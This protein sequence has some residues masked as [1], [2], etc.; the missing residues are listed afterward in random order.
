MTSAPRTPQHAWYADGEAEATTRDRLVRLAGPVA[1]DAGA[2]G[3]ETTGTRSAGGR[4]PAAP[5]DEVPRT[6]PGLRERALAAAVTGYTA[7]HGHPLDHRWADGGEHRAAP[8]RWGVRPAA[9]AVAAALLAVVVVLVGARA[10]GSTGSTVVGQD[11]AEGGASPGDP[12]SGPALAPEVGA[13]GA[14]QASDGGTAAT[15]GTD[16]SAPTTA[17]TGADVVV[18]HVAGEV[19]RPGVVTLPLGSRVTDALAAAG[20]SLPTADLAAVNLARE[21]VDGEQVLVPQPGVAPPASLT[22]PAGSPAGGPGAGASVVDLNAAD[23]AALDALP[24]IGPVLAERIVT[25]RT[26]HGRFTSVDE[27][28][29]VPGIGPSLLGD[30]RD[31]VRV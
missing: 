6:E 28:A 2:A 10:L 27:L 18:V 4:V 11:A 14:D 26:E 5:P 3:S 24:G 17:G 19:A 1:P 25:W 20:G 9:V 15:A 23:V 8:R 7:A 21:L 29:E 30:L 12:A 13:D 22:S 16:G 31:R